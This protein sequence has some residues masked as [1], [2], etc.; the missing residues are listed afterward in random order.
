[1]PACILTL[2][3]VQRVAFGSY[4][5]KL[6]LLGEREAVVDGGRDKRG[7]EMMSAG[8]KRRLFHHSISFLKQCFTTHKS[9]LY[10]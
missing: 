1:M 6:N 4:G 2:P 8:R 7:Q 9:L 10:I 3:A 5:I